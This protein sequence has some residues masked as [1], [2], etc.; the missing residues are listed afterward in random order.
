M[1]PPTTSFFTFDWFHFSRQRK[2]TSPHEP[3]HLH[4]LHKNPSGYS[5]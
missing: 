3:L 5:V 1:V 2:W 4:G